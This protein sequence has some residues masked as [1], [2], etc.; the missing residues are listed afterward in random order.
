MTGFITVRFGK[1][2]SLATGGGI[3][4]LHYA[5]EKGYIDINWDKVNRKLDKV[6]DKI[7]EKV[8]G[9]GPSWSDKVSLTPLNYLLFRSFN[10]WSG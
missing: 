6:A 1:T 9:E 2:V 7:E 5:N 8:T 4:L 10:G 3:V